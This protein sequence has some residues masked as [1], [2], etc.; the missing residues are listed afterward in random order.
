MAASLQNL[1]NII[2]IEYSV[3]G[4]CFGLDFQTK[5]RCVRTGGFDLPGVYSKTPSKAAPMGPNN[6]R[7]YLPV[8]M[9]VS[10]RYMYSCSIDLWRLKFWN[11]W[12]FLLTFKY[13]E[14]SNEHGCW[15][16]EAKK[17]GDSED[18]H[19]TNPLDKKPPGPG[20]TLEEYF[21]DTFARWEKEVEIFEQ[22]SS[23]WW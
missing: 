5:C 10:V 14:W 8:L 18:R 7:S 21:M 2:Y 3:V 9:Y 12:T 19:S 13:Y 23:K 17:K 11:K 20:K 22:N 1:S 4:R 16:L 6:P 15:L